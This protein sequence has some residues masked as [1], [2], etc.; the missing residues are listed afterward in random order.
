MKVF[1]QLMTGLSFL[2]VL[3][4]VAVFLNSTGSLLPSA[5]TGAAQITVLSEQLQREE[6]VIEAKKSVLSEQLQR[7]EQLFQDK[8]TFQ[9]Y[10]QAKLQVAEEVIAG[11]LSVAE[12]LEA[13]RRL[14]GQRLPN[15]TKQH[16]LKEWKMSE[17]EWLGMGVRYYVEQVLADRPDEA[18]AVV[19]RLKK[20]LQELLA[21]RK[22]RP[23]APVEKPIEPSR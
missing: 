23:A 14:E 16:V 2:T 17:D 5:P 4:L 8:E 12:A 11:R 7:E 22:K 15:S 19:S 20:E 18:A 1:F 3:I 6:Q 13:F 21:D 10:T 9:R